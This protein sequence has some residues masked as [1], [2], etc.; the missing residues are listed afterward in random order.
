MLQPH[1]VGRLNVARSDAGTVSLLLIG[2]FSGMLLL[3]GLVVDASRAQHANAHASDLAAKA[4]R[5]GAQEIDPASL[6]NGNYRLNPTAA[7][8]AALRYLARR[9]LRGKVQID[10]PLI[11]VTV[12]WPVRF[13]LLAP[14]KKGVTVTQTRTVVITD[15]R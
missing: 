6:R 12:A 1:T 10:G 11:S 3:S 5:V 7:R 15:G 9:H 8:T 2:V 14:I 4:A 13:W